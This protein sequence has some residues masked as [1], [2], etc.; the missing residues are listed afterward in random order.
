RVTLTLLEGNH[1]RSLSLPTTCAIGGWTIGHGHR[2]LLGDRTISGHLHPVVRIAGDSAPCFL[3]TPDRIIL[4]AFSPN[5]A[6][7]D[8][9]TARV[10]LD[11]LETRMR[12]IVSTGDDLL[13]LGP[14]PMLRRH[15]HLVS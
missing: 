12:C 14:L 3:A 9:V 1:D 8:V 15:R 13:D 7:F 4:P 5:A 10:P 6:G 11:W 2:P